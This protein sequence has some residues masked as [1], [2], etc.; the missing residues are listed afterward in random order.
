VSVWRAIGRM[1][2][3]ENG[4]SEEIPRMYFL[5]R[6]KLRG[7]STG[8]VQQTVQIVA[9]HDLTLVVGQ[10]GLTVAHTR[11]DRRCKRKCSR[12]GNMNGGHRGVTDCMATTRGPLRVG[13]VRGAYESG[14]TLMHYAAAMD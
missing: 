5:R 3:S 11:N 6:S 7:A 10:H 1:L 4:F 13:C 8:L 9:S 14:H 12:R 2:T